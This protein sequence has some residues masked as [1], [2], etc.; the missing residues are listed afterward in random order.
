[1]LHLD[2]SRGPSSALYDDWV[3][4]LLEILLLVEGLSQKGGISTVLALVVLV[5]SRLLLLDLLVELLEDFDSDELK[6]RWN[7]VHEEKDLVK[8]L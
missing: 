1:M 2:L 5:A 8:A 4:Q 6:V 7:G 3:D